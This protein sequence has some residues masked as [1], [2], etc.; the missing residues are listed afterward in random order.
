MG[1]MEGMG[2]ARAPGLNNRVTDAN[3]AVGTVVRPFAGQIAQTALHDWPPR[4]YSPDYLILTLGEY[5][6]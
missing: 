6:S 1:L 4:L 2:G 5:G 3:G